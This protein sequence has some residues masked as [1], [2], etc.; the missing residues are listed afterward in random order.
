MRIR[1][2]RSSC[3]RSEDVL[4]VVT[5][6]RV[7]GERS[8][9][10]KD[11]NR[12]AKNTR[13]KKIIFGERRETDVRYAVLDA[14][15]YFRPTHNIDHIDHRSQESQQ[16]LLYNTTTQSHHSSFHHTSSIKPV[17]YCHR[18]TTMTSAS[19]FKCSTCE[20]NGPFSKRQSKR[21]SMGESARCS[22]CI[23]S[24]GPTVTVTSAS[25]SVSVSV[26]KQAQPPAAPEETD[27]WKRIPRK[28]APKPNEDSALIDNME[29]E[30]ITQKATHIR[31]DDIDDELDEGHIS[32]DDD[33]D[34]SKDIKESKPNRERLVF[35]DGESVNDNGSDDSASSS[36][37]VKRRNHKE[38][39]R[40]RHDSSVYYD[41]DDPDDESQDDP[42]GSYYYKGDGPMEVSIAAL[43]RT[44]L[45]RDMDE[46][47]EDDEDDEDDEEETNYNNVL[48]HVRHANSNAKNAKSAGTTP[49]P[50]ATM[51][52]SL[53]RDLT[54][55]ICHD[56]FYNPVSLLC[57]HSY[58]RECLEWW[59]HES[60]PSSSTVMAQ[61]QNCPTC[62][63]PIP[64]SSTAEGAEAQLGVN[65]A[66]RATVVALFGE[67]LVQRIR[68]KKRSQ[69]GE[70]NGAHDGGYEILAQLEQEPWSTIFSST[71]TRSEINDAALFVARRSIVLDAQDQ[72]MQFAL[73]LHGD[74]IMY[75]T[76]SHDGTSHNY[77][78]Y[79]NDNSTTM[80]HVHLVLLTMEEDEADDGNGFPLLVKEEQ[81]EHLI[82]SKDDRFR[83]ST[84]IEVRSRE[85]AKP[86]G[87]ITTASSSSSPVARLGLAQSQ[88]G[89]VVLELDMQQLIA[90]GHEILVFCHS[91]TGAELE[92]ELELP[93][94]SEASSGGPPSR[95]KHA[96]LVA[97]AAAVPRKSK[98]QSYINDEEEGEEEEDD[99]DESEDDGFIVDDNHVDTEDEDEEH[100][101][102]HDENDDDCCLCGDGGELLICDG[103]DAM[104]GCGK[105][106]HTICIGRQ[107]IP[108]GDWICQ[109]CARAIDMDV[110]IQ[111]HEFSLSDATETTT[112]TNTN[113]NTNTTS[114][115]RKLVIH[116][117]DDDDDDE[118]LFAGMQ[119]PETKKAKRRCIE[120]SDDD[121]DGE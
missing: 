31:F 12:K 98:P 29:A 115:K 91:E 38:K 101:H 64:T 71:R 78:T 22:S 3:V 76:I 85:K 108:E 36:D 102:E 1:H 19:T 28:S 62:R 43:K 74:P 80:L 35:S 2:G 89:V 82:C 83:L 55:A 39:L 37:E 20:S 41:E 5:S 100:E 116:L 105:S 90:Q 66:L 53:R 59:Q 112:N 18:Y 14:W 94:F 117:D 68:A 67:E 47:N 6:C 32:D 119:Q 7:V 42:D 26:G 111:G 16:H 70:A 121:S 57:G 40:S 54:C 103:G 110:G 30:P 96:G 88:D 21:A 87:A 60:A 84:F 23:D 69:A 81:D 93:Y 95:N 34:A 8:H 4:C 10:I 86:I 13:E 120:D 17:G 50:T 107:T 24:I 27:P 51:Q 109:T 33:D 58:C 92:L 49:A 97:A 15:I 61:R 73:A 79:N 52:E 9:A 99:H 75:P 65:T 106:F 44:T 46:H 113:T 104:G 48:A 56:I 63:C 11:P 77:S 114:A 118:A 72:C 25:V 45:G